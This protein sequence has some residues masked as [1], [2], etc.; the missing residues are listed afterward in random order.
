MQRGLLLRLAFCLGVFSLCLFSYQS[1]QND[2]TQ[3]KIR[4]PQLEREICTIREE[5]QR[6]QYEIDKVESP[7]RLIEIA[8]QPQFQ[9]LKHP[10]M[11][12]I[13][14]VPEG[15]ALQTEKHSSDLW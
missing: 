1:K 12:E 15:I 14:T 13:L 2:L 8:H 11:K 6:L 5:T 4:L 9:H 3:L 10:L 7:S